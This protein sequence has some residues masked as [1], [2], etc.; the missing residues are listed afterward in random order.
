MTDLFKKLLLGVLI[1][2]LAL[3]LVF[4]MRE[5]KNTLGTT[6]VIQT[7]EGDQV[8]TQ[9]TEE[10]KV[11]E[12]PAEQVTQNV[13]STASSNTVI[14]TTLI[15]EWGVQYPQT[16]SNKDFTYTFKPKTVENNPGYSSSINFKYEPKIKG[17][18]ENCQLPSISAYTTDPTGKVFPP[19]PIREIGQHYYTLETSMHEPCFSD[20]NIMISGQD[21]KEWRMRRNVVIDIFNKL[22]LVN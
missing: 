10:N 3:F 8:V 15:K 18:W 11:P 2:G 9:P 5:N 22:E 14:G 21:D 7:T 20:K 12:Q 17:V 6:E 1:L 4:T 13:E 19:P 16:E